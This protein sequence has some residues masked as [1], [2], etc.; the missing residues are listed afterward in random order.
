MPDF[1][2]QINSNLFKPLELLISLLLLLRLLA[3]AA[4]VAILLI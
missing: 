3:A 4:I 1:S 2:T